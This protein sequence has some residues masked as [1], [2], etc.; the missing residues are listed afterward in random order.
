MW[1]G[2]TYLL[3]CPLTRIVFCLEYKVYDVGNYSSLNSFA[4]GGID[5]S[6]FLDFWAIALRNSTDYNI[7]L[8]NKLSAPSRRIKFLSYLEVALRR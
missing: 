3:I 5:L 2:C 8:I 7:H 4:L 6:M 1:R